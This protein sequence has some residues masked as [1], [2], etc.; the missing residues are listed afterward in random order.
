MGIILKFRHARASEGSAL[1][2]KAEGSA[3]LPSFVISLESFKKCRAGMALLAFQLSTA[4][5]PTPAK[6]AVAA[7]PPKA[8]TMSSTELSIPDQYSRSVNL[9][10]VHDMA[11]DCFPS[12]RFKI[13]MRE[14][15]KTIGDRLAATR[16]AI[17]VKAADLCKRIKCKPNRWSQYES[18]ERKITLTIADRLCDEYG[19][20][21]DWI[22]R[23]N[24]AMLP[25]DLRVKIKIAA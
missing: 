15:A 6:T 24:P 22:Y 4:V 5:T 8:S 13:S 7:V 9:S 3:S 21:L 19:L 10:T 25:H 2:P 1:K 14:S 17:G 16:I 20:T 18:G 11:V 23:A 12:L